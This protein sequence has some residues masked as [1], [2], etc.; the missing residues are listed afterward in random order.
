MSKTLLNENFEIQMT[1]DR[2]QHQEETFEST[3]EDSDL[4]EQA[5]YEDRDDERYIIGNDP[6]TWDHLRQNR[7]RERKPENIHSHFT[8]ATSPQSTIPIQSKA[9]LRRAKIAAE[10]GAD[11]VGSDG[12]PKGTTRF[13][14][15]SGQLEWYDADERFWRAA[16]P[17]NDFRREFIA[18]DNKMDNYDVDPA[19]GSTPDDVTSNCSYLG[20]NKWR[21]DREYGW[22]SIL[23]AD[24]NKVMFLANKP[25]RLEETIAE[26]WIHKGLVMLDIDD[27][28]VL[29]WQGIPLCFSSKLEGCRMEALRKVFPWLKGADFRAR[30]PRL[31]RTR[32]GI[33]PLPKASTFG[34]RMSRFREKTGCAAWVE[35]A[36]TAERKKQVFPELSE[37]LDGASSTQGMT[38]VLPRPFD[39]RKPRNKRDK[40]RKLGF[41]A[42]GDDI[43]E[44]EISMPAPKRAR[45]QSPPSHIQ[46]PDTMA[47]NFDTPDLG[48]SLQQPTAYEMP[49]AIHTTAWKCPSPSRIYTS[50]LDAAVDPSLRQDSLASNP[51]IQ[52]TLIP[53]IDF[54]DLAP[55]TFADALSIKS[56]L[57][58]TRADFL[59]SAGFEPPDTPNHESYMS[60]YNRI[61][62]AFAAAWL[63]DDNPPRLLCVDP[64]YGSP[65]NWRLPKMSE[66]VAKRL[67]YPKNAV[68]GFEADTSSFEAETHDEAGEVTLMQY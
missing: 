60:Q 42:D 54:R 19:R 22:D 28:P 13:H 51:S 5:S 45:V 47:Q 10:Y 49:P 12:E 59:S 53:H 64:W 2:A 52:P 36:G 1:M 65:G 55:Q 8:P 40:K 56:A 20:Q 57:Y 16:A 31:V 66:D 25:E 48:A 41:W 24:G 17:H 35:R 27:H 30:M 37:R 11:K 63:V 68:I 61:Q 23:D 26:L 44:P 46:D 21:F 3:R 34:Q 4:F 43:V 29:K 32:N 50:V 6:S 38:P 9:A 18:L 15:V 39:G 33:E 67:L 62:Q 7:K 14:P 58:C